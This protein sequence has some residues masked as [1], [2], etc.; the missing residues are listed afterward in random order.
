MGRLVTLKKNSFTLLIFCEVIEIRSVGLAFSASTIL[1]HLSCVLQYLPRILSSNS[2]CNGT[3]SH[4]FSRYFHGTLDKFM[5]K[6]S[7]IWTHFP[8]STPL[9]LLICFMILIYYC[10]ILVSIFGTLRFSNTYGTFCLR[11]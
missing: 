5:I 11:N 7:Y 3:I 2:L 6:R 8:L 4:I 9:V 10:R 1:S